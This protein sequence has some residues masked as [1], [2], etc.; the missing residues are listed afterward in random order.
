MAQGSGCLDNDVVRVSW[1][2]SGVMGWEGIH[3][4][5]FIIHTARYGSWETG[6]RSPAMMLGELKL[7]KGIRFLYEYDLNIP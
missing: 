3:L 4:Y 5:Q 2:P 1:R 7:H 6:A